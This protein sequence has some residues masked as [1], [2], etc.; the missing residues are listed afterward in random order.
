MSKIPLTHANIIQ[1][2]GIESLPL[3]ERKTIV[4]NAT[5]LI[6]T[7]TLNRIMERLDEANREKFVTALEKNEDDIVAEIF[8][9]AD[10]NILEIAESETEKIKHDLVNLSKV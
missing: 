10:I 8:A 1:I 9:N 2:L 6:E 3:D 7:E 4:E 5:N